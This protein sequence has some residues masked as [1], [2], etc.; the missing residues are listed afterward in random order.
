MDEA[1][2][3]TYLDER[4]REAAQQR[5]RFQEE[6][7]LRLDR[8][9]G[10]LDAVE[11][12]LDAV[13][14]RLETVESR[15]ETVESRLESV[16]SRLERNEEAT[17]HTQ[18]SVEA[19][20]SDIRQVAEGIVGVDEKQAAGRVEDGR[21][22]GEVESFHRSLYSQLDLRVRALE[23]WR[24]RKEQDPLAVIRERFGIERRTA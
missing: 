21:K 10:R 14:G 8:I 9:E 6:T 2:L 16:E 1:R 22:I 5:Q 4:F 13:E 19:L 15:L 17:R 18:I 11:G 24:T 23:E 20:R 7:N 12:R 3:I